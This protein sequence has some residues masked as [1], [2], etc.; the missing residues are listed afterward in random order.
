MFTTRGYAAT[1]TRA[2]A[3]RAGMRQASM[4]HYVSGKEEL[5]AELLESTVTPS[6][7]FARGSWR[8]T[9]PRPRAGCGSCAGP[10]WNCS[11]AARTTSAG[12]TCC[13]RC[14]PSASRAST[15]YGP[16][17]RAPTGS[18]WQRRPRAALS[19]RVNS[20]CGRICCSASS[21]G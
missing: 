5:L 1:T 7:A 21:K 15:P 19:P 8:T 2:V 17:S 20:T 10:T 9:R 3:E 13:P 14:A 4:Y 12:C 6:L 16:N 18:C 11:A